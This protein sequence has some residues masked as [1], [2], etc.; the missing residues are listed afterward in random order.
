M[1]VGMCVWGG[2]V[3][4]H[5]HAQSRSLR[6]G[7]TDGY[8]SRDVAALVTELRFSGRVANIFNCLVISPAL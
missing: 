6:V 5:L 2:C 8:E 4:V 7:V 1:C 3:C